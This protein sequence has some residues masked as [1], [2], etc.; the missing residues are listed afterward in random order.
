M[1]DKDYAWYIEQDFSQ[2]HGE[3]IAILDQ[4]V[5]AHNVSLEELLDV[6]NQ[7]YPDA[8]PLITKVKLQLQV[9]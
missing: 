6:V 5:I 2:Y 4:K 1:K 7:Q 3:W 9:M 8:D